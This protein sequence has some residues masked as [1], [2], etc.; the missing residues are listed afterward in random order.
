MLLIFIT[1][2]YIGLL[3]FILGG[4]LNRISQRILKIN[5]EQVLD[6]PIVSLIGLGYLSV[7]CNILSIWIP[8]NLTAHLIVLI[9]ISGC[10]II[11]FSYLWLNLIAYFKQFGWVSWSL[12]MIFFLFLVI[13]SVPIS[14]QTDE[15]KYYIQTMLWMEK[16]PVIIGIGNIAPYY[17]YNSAWHALG[18]FFRF[19]FLGFHNLFN[20]L[21][22]Y[23]YGMIFLYV[24]PNLQNLLKG[25][26]HYEDLMKVFIL[27]IGYFMLRGSVA[28]ITPDA[29]VAFFIWLISTLWLESLIKNKHKSVFIY[30]ITL[31]LFAFT[32]K[33]SAIVLALIPLYFFCKSVIDKQLKQLLYV[34]ILC[35]VFCLPY[36]TKNVLT[37]GYLLSPMTMIDIFDVD[38]KVPKA[39]EEG[40]LIG[41][42]YLLEPYLTGVTH[43][44]LLLEDEQGNLTE[45]SERLTF[46]ELFYS[47]FEKINFYGIF[48]LVLLFLVVFIQLT[49][50]FHQNSQIK[51]FTRQ[52]DFKIIVF[53]TYLGLFFLIFLLP[54][55]KSASYRIGMGF[56][57]FYISATIPLLKFLVSKIY[58]KYLAYILFFMISVAIIKSV[59]N[60]EDKFVIF[61]N[62]WQLPP[63]YPE[64]ATKAVR[65]GGFNFNVVIQDESSKEVRGCWGSS[66]PCYPSYPVWVL[67]RGEHIEDG[68]K[69]NPIYKDRYGGKNSLE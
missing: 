53:I 54:S 7:I 43:Q 9:I 34:S 51:E 23:L 45:F 11:N 28:T 40:G 37:S 46:Q 4:S 27:V 44:R 55:W 36:A 3:S 12:A 19:P 18:A 5:A 25:K 8:I 58:Q 67:P 22:G 17:T 35:V 14:Y 10:L 13:Q 33:L 59:Y 64:I 48:F 29:S 69:W 47:Y 68:F 2:L 63:Q 39:T 32:I 26:L 30:L 24:L 16:Y 60:V 50:I 38:W 57:L 56:L 66:I 65:M 61:W 52:A 15:H 21:N 62:N 1:W 6:F 49:L 31:S 41:F 42:E 20:D